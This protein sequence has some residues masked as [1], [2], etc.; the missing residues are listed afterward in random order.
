MHNLLVP[1][2]SR[3]MHLSLSLPDIY[4]QTFLELPRVSFHFL[5]SVNI[6]IEEDDPNSTIDSYPPFPSYTTTVLEDY[7]SLRQLKF[8]SDNPWQ[9]DDVNLDVN[10]ERLHVPWA[11]LTELSITKIPMLLNTVHSVLQRCP[12]LVRCTLAVA[13]VG[14]TSIVHPFSIILQI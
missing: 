6:Y 2:A 11:L 14:S 9:R 5:N 1:F 4:I 12:D 3:F 7:Q 10:L 8:N 13:P